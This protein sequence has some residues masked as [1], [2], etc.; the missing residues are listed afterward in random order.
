MGVRIILRGDDDTSL[1]IGKI[2]DDVAPTLIIVDAQCDDE[3]FT[4]VGRETKGATRSA[5]AHGEHMGSIDFSPSS[6]VGVVPDCFLDDVEERVPV[7]LVDL[8]GDSVAHPG[9]KKMRGSKRNSVASSYVV[10]D[11]DIICML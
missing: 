6:A 8:R 11:A 7:G 9:R 5:T 2:C 1:L 10:S 4:G 3:V